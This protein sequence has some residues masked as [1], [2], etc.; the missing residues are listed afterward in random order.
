MKNT[1]VILSVLCLAGVAVASRI[2]ALNM[3]RVSAYSV[4]DRTLSV[5]SYDMGKPDLWIKNSFEPEE[6]YVGK[7]KYNDDGFNQTKEQTVSPGETAIYHIGVQNDADFQRLPDN[8]EVRGPGS[9][10]DWEVFYFN[11]L[12]GGSDITPAV[13]ASGWSTGE[14]HMG[15]YEEIRM[16]VTPSAEL[17]AGS[18][19]EILVRGESSREPDQIDVVKAITTTEGS[20]GTEEGAAPARNSLDVITGSANTFNI[21][22][23]IALADE[24]DLVVYD[25]SGREVRTLVSTSQPRGSFSIEWTGDDDNGNDLPRGIYF[26]HLHT[27]SFSA[28]RKLVLV[29]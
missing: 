27:S 16:E 12:A 14:L 8:I 11:S 15:E 2:V 22:Y 19:L 29:H 26:V 7:D 9:S 20:I 6:D 28:T 1:R 25:V 17:P 10:D 13:T 4:S 5:L 18:V 21:N 23:G 3:E 24:V